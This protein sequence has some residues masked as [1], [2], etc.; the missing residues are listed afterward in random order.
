MPVQ[1]P[2]NRVKSN[3]ITDFYPHNEILLKGKAVRDYGVH[4]VKYYH[5][6]GKKMM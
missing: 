5:L 3:R 2:A 1:R 6:S 4:Q